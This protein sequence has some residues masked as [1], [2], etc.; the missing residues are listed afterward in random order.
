[1]SQMSVFLPLP[2]PL[3]Y[4]DIVGT[5]EKTRIFLPRSPTD[6]IPRKQKMERPG[7]RCAKQR[8]SGHFPAKSKSKPKGPAAYPGRPCF[9]PSSPPER[10]PAPPHT[11][12]AVQAYGPQAA[13]TAAPG[14]AGPAGLPSALP[15]RPPAPPRQR[16]RRTTRQA[17]FLSHSHRP[18]GTAA[19]SAS[20][21]CASA[22]LAVSCR[23]TA[24]TSSFSSAP[25]SGMNTRFSAG[26]YLR[27]E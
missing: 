13:P 26:E 14:A 4:N 2:P 5:A 8:A 17:P 3:C 9:I 6:P 18:N 20:T 1:M 21:N 16:A 10:H 22:G 24:M 15:C 12:A 23:Q 25:V 27:A 19:R 7:A 11:S